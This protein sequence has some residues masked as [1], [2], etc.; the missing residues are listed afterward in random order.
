MVLWRISIYRDLIGMGGELSSGRWHTL[1]EGKRVVYLSEHPALALV[2]TLVNLRN[3]PRN[4]AAEYQLL[5]IE[6]P[7]NV[8]VEQIPAELLAKNWR[9]D[10]KLTRELGDDWILRGQ[11]AFLA[12]PSVPAPESTN[13]L[14]NP[15]HAEAAGVQIEWSRWLR[16]DERFFRLSE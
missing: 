7:D 10:L 16:Y 3:R 14:F 1:A 13:Y 12:V 5:R 6:A 2:E 8:R 9:D 11:S 4:L 15:L